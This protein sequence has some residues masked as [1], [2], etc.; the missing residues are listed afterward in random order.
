VL[1]IENGFL[2]FPGKW[3]ILF[4]LDYLGSQNFLCPHNPFVNLNL[5]HSN[6]SFVANINKRIFRER[7]FSLFLLEKFLRVVFDG[8]SLIDGNNP[9]GII[10]KPVELFLIIIIRGNSIKLFQKNVGI[11]YFTKSRKVACHEKAFHSEIDINIC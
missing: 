6:Q 5:L 1:N 4:F 3:N 9:K 2:S 8:L 11:P 7:K 10:I